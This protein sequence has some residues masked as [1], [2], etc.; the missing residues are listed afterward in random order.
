MYGKS[1]KLWLL[2]G[3]V[4]ATMPF[5]CGMAFAQET[6]SSDENTVQLDTISVQGEGDNGTGPVN[7]YVATQTTTG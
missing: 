3:T 1:F 5:L 4:V 7:G 2:S 6:T